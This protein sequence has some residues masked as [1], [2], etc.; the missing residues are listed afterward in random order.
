MRFM[1]PLSCVCAMLTVVVFSGVPLAYGEDDG[2]ISPWSWSQA[3]NAICANS[4]KC[5]NDDG[6]ISPKDA[7]I[8]LF[9]GKNL[10]GL[11]TWLEDAKYEDPRK[12]F[13]VEDG[14]I[15][16]SG[17]GMGYVCTKKRYK[18]YH[19]AVEYRWGER[20]WGERKKGARDSG[21]IF[22]CIEPDGTYERQYMAGIEAQIY[23]SG[24][25]DLE[26]IPDTRTDGN[27]TA[28]AV[29]VE[30]E[31]NRR[32][33]YIWKKGGPRMTFHWGRLNWFGHDPD[34]KNELGYRGKQDIDS[35]GK[36]WTRLDVICDG[37]HILYY[38]NG[39]L[40]NEGFDA[41]PSSGRILIQCEL[42]EIYV[43]RFELLPLKTESEP[44]APMGR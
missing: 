43:R 37:D 8:Q 7:L 3:P 4:L 22:H 12:V 41:K 9:N 29:T 13:T 21:I 32:G 35:P 16:I 20:T 38:V 28:I 19:L 18:N 24:T 17:D 39:T 5:G 10:D 6:A 40:A 34:W 44:M 33:E 42:A 14:M 27:T 2:A 26:F 30:A 1:L 11:Y 25:G 36:E 31:R 23:E 15:R